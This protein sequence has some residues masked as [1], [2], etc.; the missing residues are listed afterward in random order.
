M[1]TVSDLVKRFG[2]SKQ[3][4]IERINK[5]SIKAEKFCGIF[6]IDEKEA[7]KWRVGLVKG[8]KRLKLVKK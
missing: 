6:V 8:R 2:I 1:L 5:G 3:G 7:A 4:I